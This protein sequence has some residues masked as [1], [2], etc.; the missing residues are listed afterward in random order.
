MSLD[1]TAL[2]AGDSHVGVCR[3][4]QHSLSGLVAGGAG[5]LVAVAFLETLS[6]VHTVEVGLTFHVDAHTLG[7][8]PAMV[9][10]AVVVVTRHGAVPRIAASLSTLFARRLIWF[11]R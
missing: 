5:V 1:M 9:S 3:E 4:A 6:A 11:V 7:G 2:A 10:R 8:S